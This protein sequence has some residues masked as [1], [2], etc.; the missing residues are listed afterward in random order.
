MQLPAMRDI[1]EHYVLPKASN[2]TCSWMIHMYVLH[3]SIKSQDLWM[4]LYGLQVKMCAALEVNFTGYCLVSDK[5]PWAV[6]ERFSKKKKKKKWCRT[7][8]DGSILTWV[9]TSMLCVLYM[10]IHV[11]LYFSQVNITTKLVFK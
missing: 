8:Q 1:N 9:N 11:C 10:Y 2:L 3:L 5:N 7:P 4:S 6:T